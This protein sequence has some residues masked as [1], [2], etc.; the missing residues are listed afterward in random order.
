MGQL[1]RFTKKFTL[2]PSNLRRVTEPKPTKFVHD[3]EASS[4][5]LM[6]TLSYRCNIQIHRMECQRKTRI[7]TRVTTITVVT[8]FARWRHCY[9]GRATR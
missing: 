7:A 3:L 1:R 8:A 6:R 9:A 2:D 5:L 4:P